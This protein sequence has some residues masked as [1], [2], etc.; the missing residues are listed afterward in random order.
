MFFTTLLLKRK[1]WRQYVNRS[2]STLANFDSEVTGPLSDDVYFLR[3]KGRR[4][5]VISP[6]ESN[7]PLECLDSEPVKA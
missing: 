2:D 1:K 7:Y 3:L 5:Y 4:I 6:W